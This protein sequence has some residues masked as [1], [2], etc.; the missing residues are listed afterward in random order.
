MTSNPPAQP[1]PPPPASFLSGLARQRSYPSLPTSRPAAPVRHVTHSVLMTSDVDNRPAKRRKVSSQG[2]SPASGPAANAEEREPGPAS[3]VETA[4]YLGVDW[5]TALSGGTS[6]ST[7]SDTGFNGSLPLP[8][9]P[10]GLGQPAEQLPGRVRTSCRYRADVP[11]PNTPDSLRCPSTA[12]VL[13]SKKPADYFPWTGKHA[14]DVINESNVKNGYWDRAPHPPERELNT[15][16]APLYNAFKHRSGLESLSALFSLVLGQKAKR[17]A[18]TSAS[19][20]RPPPRVT[21][22][23]A[24]RRSWIA[25]LADG[26]VPLR[27]LSRTI[28]QGIRGTSL[29]DQCLANS[30]PVNRAIWFVKC[31]GANEI[32]TLK[33]KGV[34]PNVAAGAEIKWLKDWTTNIEQFLDNAIGQC[35]SERW[36]ENFRYCLQMCTRMYQENLLDR[37]HFLDWTVK[38]FAD[39]KLGLVGAWL[40][41]VQLFRLDLMRFRKRARNTAGAFMSRF[42]ELLAMGATKSLIGEKLRSAIQ[43]L[44][45]FR[46]ACFLMPDQW[47]QNRD[48]LRSC[49]NLD[50]EPE[51]RLFEHIEKRNERLLG[52][53][54]K[55]DGET[56]NDRNVFE[57]LDNASPPFDI[58]QLSD[59]LSRLCPDHDKLSQMCIGWATSRF[60][61]GKARIYLTARLLRRWYRAG[62]DIDTKLLTFF[63]QDHDPSMLDMDA[64][65]HLFAEL[66][67]SQTFSKSRFLQTLSIRGT[68]ELNVSEQTCS[69]LLRDLCLADGEGHMVNLRSHL[70]K[71]QLGIVA[72]GNTTTQNFLAAIQRAMHEA[73]LN[74]SSAHVVQLKF[75][76]MRD[77]DWSM[78]FEISRWIRS[79]AGQLSKLAMVEVPGKPPLPGSKPF[80]LGQFLIL[81]DVLEA[82]G[83]IAVLA[84]VLHVLSNSKQEAILAALIDTIHCN[85]S[86]LSAIGALEPLHKL[87]G[88]AYIALRGM[89]PCILLFTTALIDLCQ[90]FPCQITPVRALQQ[91]LIRGDRGRA[92][93][94]CSPFSDGVA[95]SLQQAGA[96]FTD[97]FEAILLGEPNMSEQTM[98]S[99]FTVLVGRITKNDGENGQSTF[100]LCQLLARLRLFRH[101]QCDALIKKWL[102]RVFSAAWSQLHR[103]IVMELL[104]TRC[105]NIETLLDLSNQAPAASKCRDGIRSI[106]ATAML[107]HD[108]DNDRPQ[109]GY[110]VRIAARRLMMTDSARALD[111]LLTHAGSGQVVLEACASLLPEVLSDQKKLMS[112]S[113]PAAKRLPVIVDQLLSIS[114]AHRGVLDKLMSRVNWLSV[115]FCSLRIPELSGDKGTESDETD[116]KASSIFRGLQLNIGDESMEPEI[117]QALLGAMPAAV[118]D[119]IRARAEEQFYNSLPKFFFAKSVNQSLQSTPEERSKSLEALSKLASLGPAHSGSVASDSNGML[120]EK[121]T[122]IA[123]MLGAKTDATP[124][125][126]AVANPSSPISP[127]FQSLQNALPPPHWDN[128][129]KDNILG[130]LDYLTMFLR[131]T[132]TR[133][134]SFATASGATLSKAS[135]N[136][137]IK[138]VALLASIATQPSLGQLLLSNC[139][140]HSKSKIRDCISFTLDMAARLADNLSDEARILCTRIMKDRLRDERIMWLV[141]SMASCAAINNTAGHGLVM[142]HET[143]GSLGDFRPKQWEM[144][145]SGGGKEGDTCLGLGLFGAKRV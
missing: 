23:E 71:T 123:K 3:Q 144:L 105:I 118:R 130:V 132:S 31:V 28:P 20:F 137:Q 94:A 140:D 111:L 11:V 86:T 95:E 46:P 129:Y 126:N 65:R 27:R 122:I 121:L 52:L 67:R 99:L 120:I 56:N 39:C 41:L 133:A 54:L 116:G 138:L 44:A 100:T 79:E 106:V 84:D 97:D 139:D 107:P 26:D 5:L 24:K 98:T 72:V 91:D 115:A 142:M 77:L 76:E 32:R 9:A 43:G 103:G 125:L 58:N 87:Y 1:R 90:H 75:E 69:T 18:L 48:A 66:S 50:N 22:T 16:K 113:I 63:S 36:L 82:L 33:R 10:F 131:V 4:K 17:G 57:V 88:Q 143:K 136:E 89:R 6:T 12:P 14:E 37:D 135:Q 124:S 15:A 34:N 92:L 59:N 60:R 110:G 62:F 127:A 141:G 68:T 81:R 2:S 83:D 29:L 104:Y 74:P 70:L 21:L 49:M 101:A 25:D 51:R 64:Y 96:T 7:P 35:G 108:P 119:Q 85:A 78:K 112:L 53:D 134:E 109:Q 38:N 19:T 8:K 61:G 102:A 47:Q 40:P 117:I 45:N 30:V 73:Q 42:K 114:A 128:R 145:E 80:T 93:A 55:E 13:E